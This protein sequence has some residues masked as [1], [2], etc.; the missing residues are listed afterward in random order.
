VSGFRLVGVAGP[1]PTVPVVRCG[2]HLTV[3]TDI[4]APTADRIGHWL[5]GV[6]A[7]HIG[8]GVSGVVEVAG[9]PVALH[10]APPLPPD[11]PVILS[12]DDFEA[13]RRARV[14]RQSGEIAQRRDELDR[15]A[16][17]LAATRRA[18]EAALQGLAQERGAAESELA[19]L[20]ERLDIAS[21][22]RR[23]GDSLRAVRTTERR[24]VEAPA[25]ALE[26][27]ERW[28]QV[29]L[30]RSSIER[31]G[32]PPSIDEAEARVEQARARVAEIDAGA[33]GVSNEAAAH[34]Q[35][36]HEDV[37]K[38]ERALD[39]AKR[40]Q[41]RQIEANVE[42]AVRHE[43]DALA[44]YGFPSRAS[45]LVALAQGTPD[46]D[47]DETRR[48]TVEV[49]E[50]ALAD[51]E[52]ARA[53]ERVA[54]G[55]DLAEVEVELR[56][57]AASLLGRFPGVDVAGEL[58]GMRSDA[59]ELRAQCDELARRLGDAG[60]DL[61]NDDYDTVTAAADEWLA[62]N[63]PDTPAELSEIE[64]R[65]VALDAELTALAER[66][67]SRDLKLESVHREQRA[68]ATSL[69]ELDDLVGG[70]DTNLPSFDD[71][72]ELLGAAR[73]DGQS[74][75]V[76]LSG[77]FRDLAPS[78]L[79]PI[80]ERLREA[81]RRTQ[82][83][84]VTD[85]PAVGAWARKVESGVK[86]WTPTDARQEA[87]RLAER[88]A[89]EQ[90]TR[91][92]QEL[93]ERE[94]TARALREAEQR[95]V[96]EAEDQAVRAAT[97]RATREPDAR[98]AKKAADQAQRE[99]ERAEREAA[100]L[101]AREAEEAAK[102][103][104]RQRAARAAAAEKR[105]AQQAAAQHA[106][107]QEAPAPPPSKQT[108]AV[109]RAGPTPV[110]DSKRAKS[111]KTK[112]NDVT[113]LQERQ[114]RARAEREARLRKFGITPSDGDGAAPIA[115]PRPAAVR[116]S[117]EVPW[118]RFEREMRQRRAGGGN[119]S[120]AAGPERRAMCR[121]HRLIRA[122]LQCERCHDHF[123]EQCLVPVKDQIVCIDCALVAAGARSKRRRR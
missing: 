58:R 35:T 84:I 6:I 76:V 18:L 16:S 106:A 101:S 1:D 102:R 87:E 23:V 61:P 113:D 55:R 40:G 118:A 110:P 56:A 44:R 21:V 38:A 14:D 39:R 83:I 96:R 34:I 103:A 114:A 30:A 72:D 52:S 122:E 94:A 112:R 9:R 78:E 7:G 107:A 73:R 27:A 41:R 91:E 105:A 92:A 98:A 32:R 46:P 54:G 81:A 57:E 5:A 115:V 74:A 71:L 60:A 28:E 97:K 123:C 10:D 62:S 80:L 86:V 117:G 85:V 17:D 8:E 13:H 116:P 53:L 42:V 93:A 99:A 121:R 65:V 95:A 90:S 3:V 109:G 26:L 11:V 70:L 31:S 33:E 50:A 47:A 64:A 79:A 111:R 89:E 19:E 63:P 22:R 29:R 49:L 2:P 100:A 82:L 88:E 36:L 69:A 20:R 67:D 4:D 51:L 66:S 45:F 48:H 15:G 37:E 108:A 25:E 43:R 77:M 120:G 59:D 104:E 24:A 68:V 12:A 119:G 75:P